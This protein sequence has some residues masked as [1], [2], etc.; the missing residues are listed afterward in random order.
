MPRKPR[1]LTVSID[2]IRL[3]GENMRLDAGDLV[4]LTASIKEHGILQP[5]LVSDSTGDYVLVCGHR[6]LAAARRAGVSEI[7]VIVRTLDNEQRQVFM[8][9]ENVHRRYLSPL[10]EAR[11]VK[12]LVKARGNQI[13]VA[14]MLGK[15]QG[16]VS[17]RMSLLDL[18]RDLQQKV[19]RGDLGIWDAVGAMRKR[20]RPRE[21]AQPQGGLTTA[22][23]KWLDYHINKIIHRLET[24]D[25]PW[26]SEEIV[27][28]LQLMYRVLSAFAT[29]GLLIKPQA[30]C[31]QCG[32]VKGYIGRCCDDHHRIL[33]AECVEQTHIEGAA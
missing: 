17:T 4:E 11:A 10:E 25:V 13:E 28:K 24:G 6:R 8:L 22:D 2:D 21:G 32:T 7:P 5:L 18:P 19:H 23:E 30:V 20:Y 16:W 29:K 31:E 15:S 12:K 1:Q 3:S 14:E 27:E 33:C 9:L 26:T